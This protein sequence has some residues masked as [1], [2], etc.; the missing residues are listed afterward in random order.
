[1][2]ITIKQQDLAMVVSAAGR[3]VS[4][5]IAPPVLENVLL[6][7]DENWLRVQGTDREVDISAWADALVG[8]PGEITLPAKMLSAYVNQLPAEKVE[9][10]AAAG[11]SDASV[12]CGRYRTVIKGMSAREFPIIPWEVDDGI[13]VAGDEFVRAIRQV[14]PAAATDNVR[15]S[16]TGV[17]VAVREG[18]MTLATTDGFRIAV[19]EINTGGKS[20]DGEAIIPRRVAT[21]IVRNMSGDVVLAIDKGKVKCGGQKAVVTGRVIDAAFPNY[22]SIIPKRWMT[23]AQVSVADMKR[24]LGVVQL[25]AR[26]ENNICRMEFRNWDS[27]KIIVQ[28]QSAETG[29]S[30]AEINASIQGTPMA[31]AFNAVYLKEAVEAVGMEDSLFIME[32]T[33]KN[34]PGLLMPACNSKTR[35]VIMPMH[36]V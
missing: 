7:A 36:V 16:M 1:M 31:I 9:I 14:L 25:F 35:M 28:G 6:T 5:H 24:A 23:R 33:E 21:E 15:P 17:H 11:K 34:H 19:T 18:V 10:F 30:A 26:D 12:I 32:L 3:A 8:E 2:F 27:H 22:A 13:P 4:G 29:D 20:A